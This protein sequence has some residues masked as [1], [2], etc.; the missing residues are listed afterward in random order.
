[1]LTSKVIKTKAHLPVQPDR[2]IIKMTRMK[3]GP[4]ALDPNLGKHTRRSELGV[5]LDHD[6][7]EVEPKL[8][9][10]LK[11]VCEGG[12]NVLGGNRAVGWVRGNVRVRGYVKG[13]AA[14]DKAATIH[15]YSG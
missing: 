2:Q 13:R 6:E 5:H 10:L 4:S 11:W 3:A 9:R 7:I 15:V 12:G 1:M 8:R 14:V